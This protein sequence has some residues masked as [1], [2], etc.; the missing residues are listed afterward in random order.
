MVNIGSSDYQQMFNYPLALT[1]VL[2]LTLTLTLAWTITLTICQAL[3]LP[4]TLGKLL[5]FNRDAIDSVL[6]VWASIDPL[7]GTIH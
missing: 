3:T 1:L 2:T 7:L 5:H 4:L 6:N